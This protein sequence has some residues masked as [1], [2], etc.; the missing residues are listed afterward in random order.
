MATILVIDDDAAIR[1]LCCSA[2]RTA[3]FDV[4]EAADGFEGFESFQSDPADVVLCDLEMPVWDGPRAIAELRWACPGVRV[5]A[6]S[7]WRSL[8][9][10]ESLGAC[11]TPRKPF[12]QVELLAAVERAHALGAS[13]PL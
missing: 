1:T 5:G 10:A 8:W 9:A 12:G 13:R 6:M 4:R 11:A 7:G 3:G 2:L